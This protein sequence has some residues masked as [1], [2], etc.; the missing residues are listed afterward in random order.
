MNQGAMS[1]IGC[2]SKTI[3]IMDR[4]YAVVTSSET[5]PHT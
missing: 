5:L 1:L 3:D 4:F 2:I